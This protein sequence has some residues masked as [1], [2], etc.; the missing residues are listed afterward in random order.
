M[1]WKILVTDGLSKE[2]LE[3][4][5][6]SAEVS[7]I[8]G[9]TP[10][11]LLTVIADFDAVIVRG[12]TKITA[13]VMAA[14]KNLKVA[15][16]AGVGVDNIDLG[17]AREKGITVVNSPIATTVS[18][19]ELTMGLMLAAIREI[20]LADASMKRNEWLKKQ[21][22]GVELLN[23]TLGVIGYGNIGQAVSVRAQAFGMKVIA[24]DPVIPAD[25]IKATHA[26]PVSLD[27]LYQQADM[28]TMHIPL[29]A[30]TKHMLNA[31]AFAKMKDGVRIICAARGGVIDETA[32]LAAL[33][34]GKVA[35]AALD[36]LESEPPVEAE[37]AL[38]N[39][40]KVICT[41]H[42]GAQTKEAQTRAAIDI[43][44]EVLAA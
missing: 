40:P 44:E 13:A 22:E 1:T 25:V 11:D 36:V 41:P 34:A 31:E 42:I 12:R 43:S 10:E 23:K 19:A 17:A 6:K 39:H 24:Y 9:I 18:V 29:I 14:A 38:V 33:E 2:G 32:L 30:S 15:G 8:K 20:P 16:R 35:S 21:L 26:E 4:L 37:L 28:I 3:I 27:A 5:N 7:N